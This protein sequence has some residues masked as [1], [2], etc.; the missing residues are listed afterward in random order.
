[1][2]VTLATPGVAQN[3]VNAGTDTLTS[4]ENLVGSDFNDTLTGDAGANVLDGGLGDDTLNGG[5]GA[6]SLIG[7]D[8]NDN[9][10]VDQLGDVVSETN[11]AAAGGN[12][13]VTS[14]IDY[15]LGANVENLQLTGAAVTG[16]GNSLDNR[17]TGST[18]NNTLQGG[19][20]NDSLDGGLGTDT[21]SYAGA[22]PA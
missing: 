6:D 16:I 2:T 7:G 10:V 3:T 14:E 17:I 12:D 18:G 21:A 20:G 15:S 8:G 13:L 4:I 11:A 1:V 5:G 9:Y 19:L 22:T